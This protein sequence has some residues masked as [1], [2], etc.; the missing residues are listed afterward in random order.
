MVIYGPILS[1]DQWNAEYMAPEMNP[2]SFTHKEILFDVQGIQMVSCF[3]VQ[4]VFFM[5]IVT[6]NPDKQSYDSDVG[7]NS[8]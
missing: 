1:S 3:N 5:K 7:Q 4:T 2:D 6:E 8:H